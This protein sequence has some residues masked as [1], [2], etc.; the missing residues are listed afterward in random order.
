MMEICFDPK[1][2]KWKEKKHMTDV[3]VFKIHAALNEKQTGLYT[4]EF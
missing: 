1:R 3:Q 2:R 4:H